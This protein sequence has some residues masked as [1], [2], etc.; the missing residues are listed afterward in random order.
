M[1]ITHKILKEMILQEINGVSTGGVAAQDN[2]FG[3]ETLTKLDKYGQ[4][5]DKMSSIFDMLVEV[6]ISDINTGDLPRNLPVMLLTDF[7]RR[8]ED[9]INYKKLT[10][11]AAEE[12]A[13]GEIDANVND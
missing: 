11:I 4:H 3:Q 12:R 2:I 8:F 9:E 1:K 10:I 5:F 7:F 6:I 13:R